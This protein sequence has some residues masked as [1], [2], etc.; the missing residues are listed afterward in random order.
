MTLERIDET[1][2]GKSK[3]SEEVVN[4]GDIYPITQIVGYNIVKSVE[5]GKVIYTQSDKLSEA[6][7]LSFIYKHNV[8]L[9]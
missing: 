3:K 9:E 5:E 8:G 6:E 2:K 1:Q 7:V 4:V